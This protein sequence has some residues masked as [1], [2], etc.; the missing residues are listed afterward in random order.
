[1][2]PSHQLN[3]FLCGHFTIS[4]N[5]TDQ[6][7]VLSEN[8]WNREQFLDTTREYTKRFFYPEYVDF[9]F[10]SKVNETCVS[11]VKD[12]N[13]EMNITIEGHK[14]HISIKEITLYLLPFKMALFSIHI[15]QETD[16]LNNCTKLLLNLRSI[17]SYSDALL[18]YTNVVIKPIMDVYNAL[19]GKQSSN[20]AQLVENGNKLRIF[21][22]IHTNDKTMEALT[23]REKE[24]ILYELATL[25][26]VSFSRGVN[27]SNS[28]EAYIKKTMEKGKID[29][30]SNWCGLTLLDTFTIH[31]F[32]VN[33][34]LISLWINRYF[35]MI[36]IHSL[37][38]K[39]YLFNLNIRFKE[40]LKSNESFSWRSRFHNIIS[41]NVN[42]LVNE[43]EQFEQKCCFHKISYNFLPLRIYESIDK[44]LEI[45]EEMMQ[46][47][48]LMGKEKQR[49]DIINNQTVNT[50]LFFISLITLFSAIWDMSCLLDKMYPYKQYLHSQPFGYRTVT[51]FLFL[52]VCS[53]FVIIYR[54]KKK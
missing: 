27:L 54:R 14:H 45:K 21:Q 17:I 20:Y 47:F 48:F 30:F 11:F 29:V 34:K 15:K 9:C 25:S 3:A 35:R 38:Q 18:E 42:N 50:L 4:N 13:T 33:E 2:K 46:L 16:D 10:G 22:I 1:M 36:Y 6:I 53:V 32:A 12:I 51:L 28:S 44:G 8:G 41:Q 39:S 23:E 5:P 19:T 7:L 26:N 52:V 43:F 40:S 49:R 24:R 31:A 37:F